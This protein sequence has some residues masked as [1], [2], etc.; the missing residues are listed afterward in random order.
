MGEEERQDY[1]DYLFTI[2]MVGS[3]QKLS[4]ERA[5]YEREVQ[6]KSK[7]IKRL[8]KKLN[9]AKAEIK[10][11]QEESKEVQLR[12]KRMREALNELSED[13][14]ASDPKRSKTG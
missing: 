8:E 1:F 5:G 10:S 11:L 6:A 9:D 3:P 12:S 4:D 7:E 2:T 14:D 13:A